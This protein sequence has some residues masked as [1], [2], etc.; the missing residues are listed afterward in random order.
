MGYKLAGYDVIGCNEI[1]PEMFETYKRNHKPQFAFLE[2]IQE[3][4][5][6]TTFPDELMNLDILDGSPPCSSF[7]IAGAR[8]KK[9]GQK[10]KFREGQAMQVLD[11]LFFDFLDLAERLQ[12]KVIV[13]ENV[14]GMLKGN[15]RPYVKKIKKRFQEIGYEVQLF[16]L[17][18]A[19]MGVP[20]K[21]E[22]IFFIA[23]R[24]GF[25]KIKMEFNEP[26]INF[27][28]VIEQ[29]GESYGPQ[30]SEAFARWWRKT[31]PGDSLSEVHPR[32]S[33]FN[34]YKMNETKVPITICATHA[35]RPI[36]QYKPYWMSDEHITA[37][38]SFPQDY[39]F[40]KSGAQY[41]VG[42]SVPPVMIAQ[43][44]NE[45]YQQWFAK[46]K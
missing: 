14:T 35:S 28:A 21:R 27:N 36:R 3:F 15:A 2:P 11:D 42:M 10:N 39:K 16:I 38:G 1:D 33:F 12:P 6:R 41:Y 20:Q 26:I 45:I 31:K 9:W 24:M 44:S 8:E 32:G 30:I 19:S 7:S 37:C 40:G 25:P 13:A 4:K 29:C 18:A 46:Q 17:N 23:N 22:R 34:S 5:K 43:I